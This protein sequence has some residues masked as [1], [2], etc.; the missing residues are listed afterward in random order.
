MALRAA[1]SP[2]HGAVCGGGPLLSSLCFR[3]RGSRTLLLLAAVLL[4][5]A[6]I[7]R[8][9]SG[10]NERPVPSAPRGS[11]VRRRSAAAAIAGVAAAASLPAARTPAAAA[12]PSSLHAA[13][14]AA[15]I[16]SSAASAAVAVGAAAAAAAVADYS[17]AALAPTARGV[18]DWS[19]DACA[20]R[21]GFALPNA[22]GGGGGG[23]RRR[24]PPGG[25]FFSAVGGKCSGMV[26]ATVA[27]FLSVGVDVFLI[28][29][30]DADWSAFPWFPRIKFLREA[31][32]KYALARK[33][34]PDI[35]ALGYTHVFLWDE[36]ALLRPAFDAAALLALLQALPAVGIGAPFVVANPHFMGEPEYV[37]AATAASGDAVHA[38]RATPEMMFPVYSARSWACVASRLVDDR[39]PENWG[40]D[41]ARAG[42]LCKDA[43][44]NV[45]EGGQIIFMHPAFAVDHGN[46]QSMASSFNEARARAGED[47]ILDKLKARFPDDWQQCFDAG[48]AMR[49]K[50]PLLNEVQGYCID[51]KRR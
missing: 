7:L 32:A 30:D 13:A 19:A 6:A 47:L 26:D 28:G 21:G 31:G 46:A 50:L 38:V 2:P 8:Q 49:E 24:A 16:S 12:A 29:Y 51:V 10:E 36:D 11:G 3:S 35:A 48:N 33:H 1:L 23:A 5:A 43:S 39:S 42:C 27:H 14:P 4:L 25:L 34:I 17:G 15:A 18:G 45:A 40:V 9:G 44:N 37:A 41:A 22:T 20:G